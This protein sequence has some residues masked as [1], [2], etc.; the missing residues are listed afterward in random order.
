MSGGSTLLARREIVISP[1]SSLAFDARAWRDTIVV[2]S[3]GT[4]DIVST[5]GARARFGAGAIVCFER[6]SVDC[7]RNPGDRPLVLIAVTRV[8]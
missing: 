8:R 4:L 6:L 1:S 2:V 3:C 7:L 5:H